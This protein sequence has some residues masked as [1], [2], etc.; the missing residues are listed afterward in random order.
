MYCI[1]KGKYK[2]MAG[3][4]TTHVGSLPRGAERRGPYW[5]VIAAKS[6]TLQS[7]TDWCKRQRLMWSAGRS[8]P[9]FRSLATAEMGKVGYSTYATERL[10]GFGGDVAHKPARIWHHFRNFERNSP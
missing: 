2:F 10:S 3:I 9:A 5:R 4:L 6:T 1:Q 7:S 8:R